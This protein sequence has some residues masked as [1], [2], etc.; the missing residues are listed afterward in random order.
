MGMMELFRLCRLLLGSWGDLAGRVAR[1]YFSFG[2]VAKY[3]GR[4]GVSVLRKRSITIFWGDLGIGVWESDRSQHVPG[5][6]D[7]KRFTFTLPMAPS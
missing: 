1:G 2:S 5:I 7:K 6:F 4:L 3:W